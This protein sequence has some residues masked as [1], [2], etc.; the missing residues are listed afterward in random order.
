MLWKS[1]Y[2]RIFK[3]RLNTLQ[4]VCLLLMRIAYSIVL[5]TNLLLFIIHNNIYDFLLTA[6]CTNMLLSICH[7]CKKSSRFFCNIYFLYSLLFIIQQYFV[8]ILLL[9]MQDISVVSVGYD[10]AALWRFL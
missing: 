8:N 6:H 4:I 9:H 10:F 7:S 2:I 3:S 5:Q 1:K